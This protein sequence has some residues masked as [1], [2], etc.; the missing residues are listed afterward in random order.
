MSDRVTSFC[1]AWAITRADGTTLGFTDHDA[2]LAFD[3]IAFRARTGLTAAALAQTTGLSVDNSEA[4]GALSDAAITEADIAAGRYDRAEIRIWRVDWQAPETR[5]LEFRGEIGEIRHADGAFHAELRGLTDLLNQTGGRI[6]QRDCAAILGDGACGI[7][8][9]DPAHRLEAAC[10]GAED[11]RVFRCPDAGIHAEGWFTHGALRIAS[12]PAAGLSGLIKS[13]RLR[14]GLREVGLWE[15]LRAQI[16]AGDLVV[17]TA[18]CDRRAET[19]RTKFAN[20]ANFR[21]F[22]NVPGEDWLTAV[23]SRS[24][25]RDGGRRGA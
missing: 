23:P 11:G 12:G 19:C 6:F 7:D 24:Q 9:Q 8:L 16:A 18:G 3:G 10:E 13:D 15:P 21:G 5:A 25:P 2:D 22:P 20:F 14:D 17:L 4:M 1:R